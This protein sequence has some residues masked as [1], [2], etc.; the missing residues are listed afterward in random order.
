MRRRELPQPENPPL[1]L[2]GHAGGSLSPG[3]HLKDALR[4]PMAN[5]HPALLQRAG[6]VTQKFADSTEALP[7][8]G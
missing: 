3:R 7:H 5:L 6:V 8:L 1:L 2:A 4:T